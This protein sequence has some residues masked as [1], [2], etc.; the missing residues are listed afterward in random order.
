MRG[1]AF[2][3][4]SRIKRTGLLR[5][6]EKVSGWDSLAAKKAPRISSGALLFGAEAATTQLQ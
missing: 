4:P 6:T 3:A 2:P 1:V 5:A